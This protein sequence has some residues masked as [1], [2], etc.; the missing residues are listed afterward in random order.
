M[1]FFFIFSVANPPEKSKDDSNLSSR[2]GQ[3]ARK[4]PLSFRTGGES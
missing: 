4:S 2:N 1:L 3:L